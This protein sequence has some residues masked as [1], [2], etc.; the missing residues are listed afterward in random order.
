M[1]KLVV[2]EKKKKRTIKYSSTSKSKVHHIALATK[3]FVTSTSSTTV[4]RNT[5]NSST[6]TISQSSTPSSEP[7]ETVD[8]QI[9]LAIATVAHDRNQ[10][11]NIILLEKYCNI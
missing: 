11:I 2:D 7:V 9:K 4:T 3:Y 1:D 8:K 6:S 5:G 10:N